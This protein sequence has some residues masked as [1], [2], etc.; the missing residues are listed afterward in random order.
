MPVA[1]SSPAART[2]AMNRRAHLAIAA[3]LATLPTAAAAQQHH[4]HLSNL[5]FRADLSGGTTLHDYTA[6]EVGLHTPLVMGH[7]RLAYH[8]TNG[9]SFQAGGG[10]GRIFRSEANG[11]PLTYFDAVAGFRLGPVTGNFHPWID[12]NGGA[13]LTNDLAHPGVDGGIGLEYL[14]SPSLSVGPFARFGY[15]FNGSSTP[16]LITPGTPLGSTTIDRANERDISFW[17]AGISA[18]I[19]VP[20]RPTAAT[21]PP[22]PRDTDGDGVNDP[23]DQCVDTPA[24]QRPDP[25][26]RG[27]PAPDTDGDGVVDPD[28]QCVNEPAGEH[29]DP[30]RAGCPL[31]DEDGDGVYGRE[32]QCPT[33]AAGAHPNP[34]RAGCPDGDEDRDGVFDHADQCRTQ[35][36][37][38]HPDASRPG[39]PMPDRDNDNVP[40]AT[41]ACPDRPGAPS[42]VAARN[43]CPG[44]VLVQEGQVRINRP[45][46]FA[47][48]SDRILPTSNAVLT[49]VAEALRATPEIRR[50]NVEGHTDD[51]GDDA[52]NLELSRRRAASVVQW[53]STRGRIDAARFT[54]EGFGETRPVAQGTTNAI[55]AQNRRVEFR[56][57]DFGAV[58]APAATPAPAP[59][60]T[61]AAP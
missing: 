15:V 32:D 17:Q 14:V 7:I 29:P 33:E 11:G 45:V 2:F 57:T 55:R 58:E 26:R 48:N 30:E 35:P 34:E 52:A 16:A 19:R 25:A 40:D 24:G 41:D 60:A 13:Y 50:V 12:V 39:C 36:A 53:L 3:V 54:S 44:L 21:A 43:G 46:F 22:P 42:T 20:D 23:D 10:W 59:A 61:P 49:A 31:S 9:F 38:L 18:S 1:A 5:A 56:I 51:V 37:G 6:P 28:D 47:T 8:I 27:C 4:P